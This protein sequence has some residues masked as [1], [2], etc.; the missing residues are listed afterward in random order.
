MSEYADDYTL[1][2][3][4]KLNDFLDSKEKWTKNCLARTAY[5]NGVLADSQEAVSWCLSGA[6]YKTMANVGAYL[7]KRLTDFGWE[8]HAVTVF[9]D[10]DDT[11][12]EHI[13]LFLGYCID[14]R[15]WEL[16]VEASS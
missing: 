13:K 10:H 15:K 3:L 5:G 6:N 1:A 16:E 7:N 14:Y 8:D 2:G 9:N 4:I 12:F 11:T